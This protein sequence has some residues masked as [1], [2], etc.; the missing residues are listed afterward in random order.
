M[1]RRTGSL[2]WACLALALLPASVAGAVDEYQELVPG[3]KRLIELYQEYRDTVVKVKFAT[4]TV[5]ENGKE[6]VELTVQSGF[7]IDAKG[8][9]LT[10]AVPT[11]NGPRLRVEKNG[12]QLLAVPIA[13]DARTNVALIQVAKPPPGIRF[14]DLSGETRSPSIGAL[15]YAITSPLDLGPTPK[16]GMVTGRESSFSEIAFPCTYLRV[17]IASGPAEGGSPLFGSAGSLIGVSVASLPDV[18]SSYAIPARHLKHIVSQL[19]ESGSVFH[20]DLTAQVQERVNPNTLQRSVVVTQVEKG[21]RAHESGL[22]VG[23]QIVRLDDTPVSSINDWRDALFF[24]RP[25]Q[26]ASL[27]VLRDE[28]TKEIA[29]LLGSR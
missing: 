5:G 18:D 16:L 4:K 26:F 15:A 2:A 1:P 11:E 17:G 27:S 10:N 8:T 25:N 22:R 6:Q 13:S 21:S 29:L 7:Y 14:V 19:R 3:E 9:V 23:D 12:L 24:S 28:T 20:P